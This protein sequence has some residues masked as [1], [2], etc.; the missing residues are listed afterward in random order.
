MLTATGDIPS[1]LRGRFESLRLLHRGACGEWRETA[2][3]SATG[4]HSWPTEF[5]A[6]TSSTRLRTLVTREPLPGE[7]IG[8]D[9]AGIT[10]RHLID[11]TET[12]W[13]TD[14]D[15][16]RLFVQV[17]SSAPQ[18]AAS[19]MTPDGIA[20]HWRQ[21]VFA[22]AS[23]LAHFHAMGLAH[24]AVRLDNV[25]LQNG[26]WRLGPSLCNLRLTPAE[27]LRA[28][29]TLIGRE[30][31]SKV[32]DPMVWSV[33]A[34]LS[35]RCMAKSVG[36][37]HIAV[38]A[39][40]SA[41]TQPVVSCSRVP[42][43]PK[44]Q[45]LSTGFRLSTTWDTAAVFVTCA[46]QC[47]PQ[48]GSQVPVSQLDQLGCVL[49]I[50]SLGHADMPIPRQTTAAF[51]ADIGHSVATVGL[52]TL[53][54]PPRGWGDLDASISPQGLIL[55]WHWP[56]DLPCR[57][58]RIQIRPDRYPRPS[59]ADEKECH[60]SAYEAAG[61]CAVSVPPQWNRAFVRVARTDLGEA[62]VHDAVYG[63]A[64]RNPPGKGSASWAGIKARFVRPMAVGA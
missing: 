21:I 41:L 2:P 9:A 62:N 64:E 57:T 34:G 13:M 55:Q 8:A 43:V 27:D 22:V 18:N 48:P 14:T 11:V 50:S 51:C 45:R 63:K 5:S 39:E 25:F 47:S 24:G 44:V 10:H 42:A 12:R 3:V 46:P 40:Q 29:A 15:G 53:V 28:L 37:A 35:E 61:R 38:W 19:L 20:Q 52:H 4:Q 54:D 7:T 30:L 36:A 1:T 58:M 31:I 49:G 16:R 59:D 60:R 17:P 32:A 23:A 56:Q 26:A 33:L 6:I